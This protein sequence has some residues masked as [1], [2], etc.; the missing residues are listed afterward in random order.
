MRTPGGEV[1]G[2]RWDRSP[3][4]GSSSGVFTVGR[5]AVLV[6]CMAGLIRSL[7]TSAL[8]SL[9]RVGNEMDAVE[10]VAQALRDAVADMHKGSSQAPIRFPESNGAFPADILLR[11]PPVVVDANILRDDILRVCRTGQRTALVTAAN[12]GVL[13]LFCAEHVFAEVVKHSGD[14]AASVPVTRE[15][16]LRQWLLEYLPLL[17]IVEIDEGHLAWLDPAE[18]TRINCL[19]SPD[20]DPDDVP[21]AVT[22]A[23]SASF[24][25]VQ[26]SQG[27]S[28]CV[29]RCRSHGAPSMGRC[30]QSRG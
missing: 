21:S 3:V 23:A 26:R 17:R 28:R 6:C 29:W 8:S 9:M 12:A 10:L 7:P 2:G 1:V 14:W 11:P 24:L 22:S 30:T 4:G 19:A 20:Q 13:R 5:V 15:R 18:L 25:P 16:F 27:T